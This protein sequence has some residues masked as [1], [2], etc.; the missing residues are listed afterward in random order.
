M[1]RS[2]LWMTLLSTVLATG[3][4]L[5]PSLS[6]QT[7]ASMS[8]QGTKGP[9]A[10]AADW[11]VFVYMAGDNSLSGAVTVDLNE[12]EAGLNSDRVR[13]V[14][15]A[16]QDR[17]GD[18]RI[19]EI[20]HDPN[21]FNFNTVSR[22]VDDGGAVI[23]ANHEVNTGDPATLEKFMSWGVKNYP[24]RR[25]MMVMWNHGGGV[26]A[27]PAHLKSFCWD[28]SSNEAHLN[29]VDFWRVSQR[30]SNKA[31]FDVIGFDTCLLGHLE[32]AFQLRDLGSFL[33]SSEKTEPGNGWDYEALAKT[34]SQ[35]PTMY[36]REFS[37]KIVSSY[38]AFYKKENTSDTT[39]SSM[40]LEKL[41]NRL[42]PSVGELAK[43]L[44]SDLSNPSYGSEIKTLLAQALDATG[45]GSGEED[46][47]DLGYFTAS[48]QKS[49]ALPNATKALAARVSTELK[50]ATVANMTT[51]DPG[52]YSGMKIYY[53]QSNFNSYYGDAS[54][55]IFGT[56]PWVKF[57]QAVSTK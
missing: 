24:S 49:S 4:G 51:T 19:L 35:N 12:M 43:V 29:L 11:T 33:V 38:N 39:L 53:S 27:N 40:D 48:L 47:I 25:S 30:L 16:D 41:K 46:A 31:K 37:S 28:D 15:L 34:L 7:D 26:F 23:P 20:Q 36:P 18:S 13:I 22:V 50:A 32:T 52:L 5:G 57:L 56:T 2:A 14:A 17:Q 42:V 45:T 6:G 54:H 10:N 8:A 55:Q 9:K 3:C 21:G 44:Q 1:K